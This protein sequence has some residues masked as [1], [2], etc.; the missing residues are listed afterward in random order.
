MKIYDSV[1]EPQKRKFDK[2]IQTDFAGSSEVAISTDLT[3]CDRKYDDILASNKILDQILQ[4]FNFKKSLSYN[5]R[6]LDVLQPS[7]LIN[8]RTSVGDRLFG[9]VEESI[10]PTLDKYLQDKASKGINQILISKQEVEQSAQPGISQE[11]DSPLHNEQQQFKFEDDKSS[12]AHSK[13]HE[14]SSNRHHMD[15]RHHEAETKSLAR[16]MVD[17]KSERTAK[18]GSSKDKPKQK[19][20][21]SANRS[22]TKRS[23]VA[24]TKKSTSTKPQ[25]GINHSRTLPIDSKPPLTKEKSLE[26]LPAVAAQPRRSV[27]KKMNSMKLERKRTESPDRSPLIVPA[28]KLDKPRIF[29]NM[30]KNHNLESLSQ[31]S[32][33]SSLSRDAPKETLH[34][35]ID[36]DLTDRQHRPDPSISGHTS[37]SLLRRSASIEIGLQD[38]HE[39]GSSPEHEIRHI[40]KPTAANKAKKL[41]VV[42]VK[43][44]SQNLETIKETGD[45]HEVFSPMRKIPS[46][47][48]EVEFSPFLQNQS[49][50]D[51]SVASPAKLAVF[52]SFKDKIDFNSKDSIESNLV[53]LLENLTFEMNRAII[54]HEQLDKT[55]TEFEEL[56]VKFEDLQKKHSECFE[57]NS[58]QQSKINALTQDRDKLLSEIS[59]NHGQSETVERLDLKSMN[60]NLQKRGSTVAIQEKNKIRELTQIL[61]RSNLLKFSHKN[62]AK[63]LISVLASGNFTQFKNPMPLKNLLKS[64]TTIYI[65][66]I[67]DQKKL[68]ES[69]KQ[70]FDEYVYDYYMQVF[71]IKEIGEKK[72][73]Y[74]ILSLKYHANYFRVNLFSRFIGIVHGIRYNQEQI[75]KYLEGIE[76]LETSQKGFPIK[77]SDTSVRVFFPFVRAEDYTK[78]VFEKKLP[79]NEYYELKKKVEEM[80][81]EDKSGMNIGIIDADLFL[82]KVIDKYESVVNRTKQY[83]VD[84]F[85]SCDLDGN[86]TCTVNEWVLLSRYIEPEKFDL[87]SCI[88]TF[89]DNANKIVAGESCMTFDRFAAVCTDN[90]FFSEENQSRFLG[91]SAEKPIEQIHEQLK[92]DWTNKYRE[93]NQLLLTL[94]CLTEE[95]VVK[96]RESLEVLNKHMLHHNKTLIKSTTIAYYLTF[97]ELVRLKKEEEEYEKQRDSQDDL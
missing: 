90:R 81:E 49:Q 14:N 93:L 8:N 42:S 69:K 36:P 65:E 11:S 59:E 83:V 92:Q 57:K 40:Q 31:R 26:K 50:A 97:N 37:K 64:I 63:N 51:R 44:D 29:I 6:I 70:D 34:E 38:N 91:V 18:P 12:R 10:K 95:E 77:N 58:R 2:Q 48:L 87:N 19:P 39:D 53:M 28:K 71:G 7:P 74:F 4:E 45:E 46:R 78:Q 85:E 66:K 33:R 52:S 9:I 89:F 67:K 86:K 23:S 72:F 62:Q 80:R 17:L 73:C 41:S 96:W 1:I 55:K 56:R 88:Q 32:H 60:K 61:A 20:L 30:D 24:V 68:V 75:E 15:D 3:L 94:T 16:S 13:R 25:A 35:E 5:K 82:E 47:K 54:Y 21:A 76:F 22:N 27:L 43:P 79:F 84:A